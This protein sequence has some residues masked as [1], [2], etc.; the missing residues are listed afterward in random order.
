MKKL[1]AVAA[2]VAVALLAKKQLSSGNTPSFL[3]SVTGSSASDDGTHERFEKFMSSWKDG[4][5]SLNDAEQAAACRWARGK[6]FIRDSD[7]FKNS[8]DGFDH[9]RKAKALYVQ[10]I[11][12]SIGEYRV[13]GD[14]TVVDV[15]INGSKYHV[16]IP[17][18]ASP[19]FWAD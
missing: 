9:W 11:S 3:A 6:P 5:V 16:G 17:K 13:E 7:D 4:G 10:D 2:V 12:Y 14:H 18:D 15:T 1:I 8:V 19:M